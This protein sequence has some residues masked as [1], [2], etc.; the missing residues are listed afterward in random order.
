MKPNPFPGLCERCLGYRLLCGLPAC[1]VIEWARSLALIQLRVGGLKLEG[2]TPPAAIVG[3]KGYPRVNLYIMAPPGVKGY[4]ARSFDDP[5]G[6]ASKGLSLPE[7][8]RFRLGLVGARIAVDAKSG[9]EKLYESEVGLAPISEEPVDLEARLAS[10]PQPPKSQNPVLG[11]MGPSAPAAKV[12]VTGSPKIPSP[13]EKAMWDDEPASDSLPRLYRS[14]VSVYTLQR[15]LSLGLLGRIRRRRLVP[16]RWAIAAVYQAL[17]R[18]HREALR[19]AKQISE[20]EVYFGEYLGNRFLIVLMP[21]AGRG[22]WIE[23]WIRQGGEKP[24]VYKL[25]ENARGYMDSW[26]GGYT[27]ARQAVLEHLESRRVKADFLIVREVL[28]TYFTSM[29]SWVI[30]ETVK[31]ALNNGPVVTNPSTSELETLASRLL[32][33]WNVARRKSLLL[34][35]SPTLEDYL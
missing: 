28:P 9:F 2:S 30:R 15:A 18:S 21:G 33:H 4:E 25:F 24:A 20:M 12:S 6:W 22:E 19:D 16:T 7:V 17:S 31:K 5:E 3:E 14:G 23:V 35:A 1:P 8:L 27:A 34:R 13:L 26:D 32:R 10:A 29:G 11:V